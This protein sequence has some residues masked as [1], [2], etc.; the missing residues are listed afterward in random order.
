ML[1]ATI[2]NKTEKNKGHQQTHLR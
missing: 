1:N 2:F